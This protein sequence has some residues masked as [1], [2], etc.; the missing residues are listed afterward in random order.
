ME[1]D[2]KLNTEKITPELINYIVDKIV[3]EIQPEKIIL[4]GSYAKGDFDNSSDL[5]LFV[6]KDDKKLTSSE[7]RRK[8]DALLRGRKFSVD[9]F[10]RKPSEV[11]MN[12]RA[13]NPFYLYHVFQDGKVLYEKSSIT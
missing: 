2:K 6:I 9:L 13:E 3:R 4:F 11:E 5:D 12:I 8:V 10:V 1:R 7:M